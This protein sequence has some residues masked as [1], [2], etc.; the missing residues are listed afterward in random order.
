MDTYS[1]SLPPLFG[2]L[3]DPT[4]LAVVE[5]LASGAASVSELSRPFDMARPSFLKHLRVL[6]NAGIV[7]SVKKGRVRTVS[8]RPDAISQIDEWVH[9][10]RRRVEASLDRLGE[11]LQSETDNER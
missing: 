3:A 7:T 5:R 8:L 2:A 1:H 9:W 10:H 11:F 4:R 6:E